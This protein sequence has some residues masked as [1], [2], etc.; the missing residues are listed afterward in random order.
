[1]VNLRTL[2]KLMA[3]NGYNYFEGLMNPSSGSMNVNFSTVHNGR[4][5]SFDL[6]LGDKKNDIIFCNRTGTRRLKIIDVNGPTLFKVLDAVHLDPE[7][8]HWEEL[9]AK[10]NIQYK[11]L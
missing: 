2:H 7:G 9:E 3:E 10:C 6:K 4:G 11:A 8:E 1:M 5:D